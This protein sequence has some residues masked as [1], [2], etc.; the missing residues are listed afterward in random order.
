MMEL[1]G[2][3]IIDVDFVKNNIVFEDEPLKNYPIA[4]G[5][6]TLDLTGKSLSMKIELKKGVDY[7]RPKK[8]KTTEDLIFEAVIKNAKNDLSE[9]GEEVMEVIGII[10]ELIGNETSETL[11][12][13]DEVFRD[14]TN[15]CTKCFKELPEDH[16]PQFA[17]CKSCRGT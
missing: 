5:G 9:I 14:P 4:S 3:K 6:A 8:K 7:S 15:K 13:V 10:V 12:S 2:R 1:N 16:P 17:E 11:E